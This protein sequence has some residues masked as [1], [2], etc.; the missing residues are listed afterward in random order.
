MRDEG[1][2]GGDLEEV[3]SRR[4]SRARCSLVDE[5][6]GAGAA[7]LDELDLGSADVGGGGAVTLL[8]RRRL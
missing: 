7:G 4:R 6:D 2:G 5:R 1:E 3:T 8:R